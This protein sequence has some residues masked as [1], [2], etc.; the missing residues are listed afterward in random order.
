MAV[1]EL[2]TSSYLVGFWIGRSAGF[3]L[4]DA[5]DIAGREAKLLDVIGTVGDQVAGGGEVAFIVDRGQPVPC[6]KRDD[7]E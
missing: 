6:R 5:I 4:E 7:G 3:A 1:F 2:I